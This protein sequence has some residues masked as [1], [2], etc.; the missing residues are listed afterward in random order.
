MNLLLLTEEDFLDD[1]RVVVR[2]ERH[3]HLWKV[4]GAAPGDVLRAGLLGGRLGEAR[5]CS[6]DRAE[7]EAEVT[8]KDPPPE[9]LQARLVLALPRPKFLGRILQSVTAMGV[10]EVVLLQTQ[11]VEKSYWESSVLRPESVRRHLMLGLAQGRDTVLPRVHLARS[12]RGFLDERLP[13]LLTDS[14]GWV[15][16]IDAPS[17]FP[18]A[19]RE[20]VT[21]IIGPEGG[22]LDSEIE[23][24]ERARIERYRLGERPLRVETAVSVALGRLIPDHVD[25][26]A[27]GS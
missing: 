2:G 19:V 6:I 21:L 15:A 10:K 25:S 26:A 27:A 9:P 24:L 16:D 22:L 3:R 11:R 7:I 18:R 12:F 8:L 17:P 14:R 4:L 1:K 13:A 5:V 23:S 20:A